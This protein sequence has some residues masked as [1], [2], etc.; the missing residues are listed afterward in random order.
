MRWKWDEPYARFYGISPQVGP[1]YAR[2][3][4]SPASHGGT[5]YVDFEVEPDVKN[6]K[7]L[8]TACSGV[9]HYA[10]RYVAPRAL[11][12]FRHALTAVRFKVGRN[13]SWNKT[14]NKVEI[15]GAMSR[16]R[17]TLPTD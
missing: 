14:I 17:Y 6:Q 9:V 5:P 3:S 1:G 2:L 8:M 4:V 11:L 15:T 10:E 16:G 7:D 12:R 13:L